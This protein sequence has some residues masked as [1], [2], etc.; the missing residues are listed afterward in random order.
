MSHLGIVPDLYNLRRGLQLSLMAI[1]H[2]LRRGV[3]AIDF[4]RA[5]IRSAY[6]SDEL[7]GI[8]ACLADSILKTTLKNIKI[9]EPVYRSYSRY[10]FLNYSQ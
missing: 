3:N 5:R 6:K 9:E 4:P 2:A 7:R 8:G 10:L 1:A